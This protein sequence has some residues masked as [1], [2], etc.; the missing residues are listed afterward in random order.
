LA[1]AVL[2]GDPS[3]LNALPGGSSL[4]MQYA[5]ADVE[6]GLG[7]RASKLGVP[8]TATVVGAAVIIP[9]DDDIFPAES[10]PSGERLEYAQTPRDA[11]TGRRYGT[12][13]EL[14][15]AGVKDKH[16]IIQDAA[17]R[18]L[19]GYNTDDAPAVEMPGPSTRVGT[20][21][22]NATQIQLQAGGGTY[23][24]ELRI[25]YKALRV[26][27]L[28]PNAA[29]FL[30]GYANEYFASIGVNP[31]TSTRIPGNRR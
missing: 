15:A 1:N 18:D 26:G 22:Y 31:S 11:A 2:S 28:S 21:H 4:P 20:P 19:P 24:A 14:Q 6:M 25:A 3:Y 12:Y 5:M 17:V 27:G 30:I 23:A 16:H 8:D 7:Y 29:R 9:K 13:S 10:I